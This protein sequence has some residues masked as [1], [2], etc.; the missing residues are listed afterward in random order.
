MIDTDRLLLRPHTLQDTASIFQLATDP[1]VSQ[2]IRGLPVSH[3]EAWQRLLR[4]AGHWSLL[5]F[6]MFAVFERATGQFI[7]EVG[8]ADFQRGLGPDF[9]GTPEAA[10]L[11]TGAS[12]GRGYAWEAMTAALAWLDGQRESTRRV[13]IIDVNNAASIKLAT[14]LGF[15]HYGHA[16]YRGA[17]LGKYERV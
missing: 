3:E 16:T 2:F 6:G 10:W 13:C 15:K 12:H 17:E 7:G 5:G 8:L 4:Y 1:A 9:D 14:K 11:F